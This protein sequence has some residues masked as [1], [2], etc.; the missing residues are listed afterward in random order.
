MPM[1]QIKLLGA[2]LDVIRR[3]VRRITMQAS[4]DGR[5]T[6]TAPD[7]M[8]LGELKKY[9]SRPRS[10][11]W[12]LK[13]VQNERITVEGIDIEVVRKCIKRLNLRVLP[14]GKVVLSAPINAGL[15]EIRGMVKARMDWLRAALAKTPKLYAP[16]FA[17]G[18]DV[19]LWGE[20]LTLRLRT[21][22][23]RNHTERRGGSLIVCSRRELTP[24]ECQKLLHIYYESEL[25]GE[26][27]AVWQRCAEITGVKPNGYLIQHNLRSRWGCCKIGQKLIKMNTALVRYPKV[28]THYV[29]LHEFNHLWISGHNAYFY[30]NMDK[31]MPGWRK[32][33]DRLKLPPFVLSGDEQLS[34]LDP[35]Q[36]R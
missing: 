16:E 27:E 14:G 1:E 34:I 31:F 33:R 13:Q 24:S 2:T 36:C 22:S 7:Y 23:L 25:R 8:S 19:P 9:V 35:F 21:P 3:P 4:P 12:I 15:E 20:R 18:E 11:N 17:D 32:I 28:C 29:L 26:I 5:I 10:Y 6:V 30:A